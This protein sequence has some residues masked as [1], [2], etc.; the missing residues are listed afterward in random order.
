M[1][2]FEDNSNIQYAPEAYSFVDN[3]IKNAIQKLDNKR[4]LTAYE[5][6]VSCRETA[7]KEYG[8]L[9]E[10]VLRSWGITSASDIGEIVYLMIK[11]NMLSASKEDKQSDFEIQFDLFEKGT[12]AK[13]TIHPRKIHDPIICD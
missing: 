2:S 3:A 7:L 9:S 4:H 5:V 8:F 11:N 10:E 1:K 13:I 12:K 6:L